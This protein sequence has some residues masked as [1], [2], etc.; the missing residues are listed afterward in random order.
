MTHSQRALILNAVYYCDL[1]KLQNSFNQTFLRYMV[2][3]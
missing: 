3:Y 1:N 2:L